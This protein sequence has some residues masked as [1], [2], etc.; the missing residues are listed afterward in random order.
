MKL[1]IWCPICITH[2]VL[3][4]YKTPQGS[5]AAQES[6]DIA[7]ATHHLDPPLSETELLTKLLHSLPDWVTTVA[8]TS[9]FVS[10]VF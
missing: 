7:V 4:S 6:L 9:T 1:P 8:W 2:T 5:S 3:P 10:W